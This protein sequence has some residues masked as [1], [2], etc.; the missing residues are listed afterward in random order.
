MDAQIKYKIYFGG[1]NTNTSSNIY[2]LRL[3]V[4]LN[5]SSIE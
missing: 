1:Y 5:D 3:K 2:I 4:K